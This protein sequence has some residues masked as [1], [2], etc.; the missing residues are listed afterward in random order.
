MAMKA[1]GRN[2]YTVG[3][4]YVVVGK[5]DGVYAF[6]DLTGDFPARILFFSKESVR[7]RQLRW[8]LPTSMRFN[9]G[10]S[11]MLDQERCET[12]GSLYAA[13]DGVE[14]DYLCYFCRADLEANMGP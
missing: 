9:S 1:I 7:R 14:P 12:C 2:A 10:R 13:H 6:V 4:L 11:L 8:S 3:A 5:R